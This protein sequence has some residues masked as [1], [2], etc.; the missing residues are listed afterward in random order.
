LIRRCPVPL[1]TEWP[2]P[3]QFLRSRQAP[4]PSVRSPKMRARWGSVRSL[5]GPS[6]QDRQRWPTAR[7]CRRLPR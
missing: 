2:C 1:S 7:R 3:L 5:W 6:W 4:L